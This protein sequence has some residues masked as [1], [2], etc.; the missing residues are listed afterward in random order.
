MANRTK[1]ITEIAADNPL[2]SRL[3][4]YKSDVNPN[5]VRVVAGFS[6]GTAFDSLLSACP[7]FAALTA[8]Q[9]TNFINALQAVW[10]DLHTLAGFT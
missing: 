5:P 4:F 8:Q 2:K 3:T 10:G 7:T 9:Q 6:D 1:T